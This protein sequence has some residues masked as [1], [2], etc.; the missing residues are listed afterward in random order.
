MNIPLH[1]SNLS[2]AH[3]KIL[4]QYL[5][6]HNHPGTQADLRTPDLIFRFDKLKR[7][8]LGLVLLLQAKNKRDNKHE[9]T[10]LKAPHTDTDLSTAWPSD[11]LSVSATT[12]HEYNVIRMSYHI[13]YRNTLKK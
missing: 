10:P 11:T 4:S 12:K 3:D 8:L 6:C 13:R 7:Q 5:Q 9:V 1:Y 2:Q